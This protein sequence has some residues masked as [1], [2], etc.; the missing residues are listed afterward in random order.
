MRKFSDYLF[1]PGV[2]PLSIGAGVLIGL[3]TSLFTDWITGG[4]VGAVAVLILSIVI[5]LTVFLQ[6][7]PYNR[8]KRQLPTPFIFDERVR[9]DARGTSV[10]GYF[11]LT[12]E[13]MIFLALEKGKHRLELS[14]ADVCRISRDENYCIN[15]YLNEQ[16]FVRVQTPVVEEM[17]RVLSEKGWG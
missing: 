6:D 8:I 11:I 17:L 14:K 3:G 15:I 5:P 16:E 4:F 2:R 12:E 9:F 10:S 7:I 1:A 13:R